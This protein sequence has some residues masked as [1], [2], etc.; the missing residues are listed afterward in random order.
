MA[1]TSVNANMSRQFRA[2]NEISNNIED[3]G[4][5]DH[6]NSAH[7]IS[8]EYFLQMERGLARLEQS[9]GKTAS[10]LSSFV[11]HIPGYEDDGTENQSF[12]EMT[13]NMAQVIAKKI[14][15]TNPKGTPQFFT[16]Q[17][18]KTF[19]ESFEQYTKH[20]KKLTDMVQLTSN[21]LNALKLLFQKSRAE[22][23][24]YRR[25]YAAQNL[26]FMQDMSFHHLYMMSSS[27]KQNNKVWFILQDMF[28][29][30]CMKKGGNNIP[31]TGGKR[32]VF[33]CMREEVFMYVSR[34]KVYRNTLM[35]GR[36][37]P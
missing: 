32:C 25:I 23:Y 27:S 37:T 9:I 21:D 31:P 2:H 22:M 10:L 7:G 4:L 11:L 29:S 15:P 36:I 1:N 18:N 35:F 34:K 14:P 16:D 33:S 28:N 24:A 13:M 26:Q 20:V 8:P 5:A 30:S 12:E 6:T 3:I 19:Q 17:I